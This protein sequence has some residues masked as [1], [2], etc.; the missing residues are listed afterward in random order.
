M[1][2]K[3]RF[4]P[5][6]S[7][8]MHLGNLFSCLLA[9][10]DARAAGGTVLLRIEDL[11]RGRCR[12][13]H[14][15]Q[16]AEDLR[17]LG[18]DWDEGYEAGGGEGPYLQSRRTELYEAAFRRLREA[19]LVYP[20]WCS[21]SQRLAASAPHLGEHRD[22][23]ACPCRAFTEEERG[24]HASQR[25]PAWKAAVPHR[26]VA[27]TDLFQGPQSFDLAEDCGDF[28]VRRSD[29]IFGYQLAV[30]VDD[31]LMGVT[32]VVRGRDLL[33]SAARQ[34]HGVPGLPAA[35]VWTCAPAAL[36]GR[37][38]PLQAGPGSGCGPAPGGEETG[39]GGGLAGHAGGAVPAGDGLHRCGA[40]P[41]LSDARTAPNRYLCAENG[42]LWRDDAVRYRGNG[43]FSAFDGRIW[44]PPV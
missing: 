3:G 2:E 16:A 36:G 10:L 9:W 20:C 34:I 23:G 25:P 18:L 30:T 15:R 13:E 6:P 4:A 26:S 24:L 28:V 27:F 17:W 31:A 19:G 14:A 22:K 5:S 41:G 44:E 7:G 43:P 1:A 37:P 39:G 29:G 33:D 32:R 38:P 42:G 8:R 12:E 21:R 40:A 11:D 35:Q